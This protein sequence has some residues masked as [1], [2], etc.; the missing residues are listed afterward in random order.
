MDRTYPDGRT[1]HLSLVANPSRCGE[2]KLT[3]CKLA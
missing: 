3:T 2:A 1:V